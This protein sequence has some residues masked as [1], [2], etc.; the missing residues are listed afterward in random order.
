MTQSPQQP[1][2]EVAQPQRRQLIIAAVAGIALGLKSSGASALPN[3]ATAGELLGPLLEALGQDFDAG[4]VMAMTDVSLELHLSRILRAPAAALASLP[5][6][7]ELKQRILKNIEADYRAG[8]IRVV[9]GWW[10]SA[11]EAYCLELIEQ[12]RAG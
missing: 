2:D 6:A 5:T 7:Q 11:T 4:T 1:G 8:E 3:D 12:V 10:L 9:N